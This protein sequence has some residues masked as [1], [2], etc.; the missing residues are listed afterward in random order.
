MA[1]DLIEP[2]PRRK[3]SSYRYWPCSSWA[4]VVS[5]EEEL[6]DLL[7]RQ[8]KRGGED[9]PVVDRGGKLLAAVNLTRVPR[10]PVR[11]EFC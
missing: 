11:G 8:L 6:D 5:P 4:P 7:Q 10:K 3:R 1:N 9:M 2:V